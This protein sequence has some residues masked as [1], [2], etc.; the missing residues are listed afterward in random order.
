MV[1]YIYIYVYTHIHT[2]IHIYIYTLYIYIYIVCLFTRLVEGR[3]HADVGPAV[4]VVDL[5]RREYNDML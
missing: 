4:E 2:H 5:A 1:I 3:E